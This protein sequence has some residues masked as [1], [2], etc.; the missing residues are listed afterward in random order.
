MPLIF[1][2]F[3]LLTT[4]LGRYCDM[5]HHYFNAIEILFDEFMALSSA[6]DFVVET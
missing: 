1:D 3:K 4:S 6:Q 2:F 5:Q